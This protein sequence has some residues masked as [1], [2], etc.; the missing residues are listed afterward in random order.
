MELRVINIVL[1]VQ[2]VEMCAVTPK[3]HIRPHGAMYRISL[4]CL[5]SLITHS[6]RSHVVLKFLFSLNISFWSFKFIFHALLTK[7]QK[8]AYR[9]WHVCLS[10]S[11]LTTNNQVF[12]NVCTFSQ[13]L[14]F[15]GRTIKE[16]LPIENRNKRNA[17]QLVTLHAHFLKRYIHSAALNRTMFAIL[18]QNTHSKWIPHYKIL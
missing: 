3:P 14:R 13:I 10:I 17:T 18:Y 6:Y 8:Y 4:F 1:A 16:I 12:T 2:R 15:S 9:V 5:P 11:T 7:M